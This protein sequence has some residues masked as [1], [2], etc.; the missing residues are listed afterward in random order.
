MA[1]TLALMLAALP[2]FWWAYIAWLVP[3]VL[4]TML[5][6]EEERASPEP[7]IADARQVEVLEPA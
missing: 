5:G 2:Q 4:L 3:P 7:V 1:A 6:D